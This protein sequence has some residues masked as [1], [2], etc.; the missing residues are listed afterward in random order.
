M[1]LQH[2]FPSMLKLD[3]AK[4]IVIGGGA[5]AERKV[6][7]LLEC[8]ASV[9][10]I[11]PTLTKSLSRLAAEKRLTHFARS[12]RSGDLTG[13]ALAFA[14][15]DDIRVNAAVAE[16]A[17]RLNVLVNVV[18]QPALCT[19]IVPA[20][21]RQGRLTIAVST[22]GV[23]PAWARRIKEH[24]S[25]EFGKEYARLLDALATV[26]R[27]CLKDITDPARRRRFLQQ[28][29]DDSLLELA[30][31]KE[32]K[33]LEAEILERLERWSEDARADPPG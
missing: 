16:E 10:V 29:A 3:G 22:G 18:D 13:A 4:V 11:A 28:L 15:I 19:F 31:S 33:A 8:G 2:L 26:R 6:R 12:F 23:S 5:V 30:R 7:S 9:T 32:V 20:V 1:G 14:A 24:M 25:S 27:R 17:G 21:T